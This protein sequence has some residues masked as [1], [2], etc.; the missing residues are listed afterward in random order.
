MAETEHIIC[1]FIAHPD[2]LTSSCSDLALYMK[3]EEDM[4]PSKDPYKDNFDIK[5]FITDHTDSIEEINE[6][7]E[8]LP[9][10]YFY[11]CFDAEHRA[12]G[13][14][15]MEVL[16]DHGVIPT[17]QRSVNIG[18][19]I[20]ELGEIIRSEPELAFVL[21]IANDEQPDSIDSIE[22]GLMVYAENIEIMTPA[23]TYQALKNF[24]VQ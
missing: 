4:D 16:A 13:V 19:M 9:K 15:L 18:D 17:E 24:Q 10:V 2:L 8:Q 22:I 12:S 1:Y 20:L 21:V 23:Q 5:L 11:L 14:Q 6:R 7:I 3:G